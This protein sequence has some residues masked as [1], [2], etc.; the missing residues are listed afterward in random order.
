MNIID[1]TQ[2]SSRILQTRDHRRI[3]NAGQ[4]QPVSQ[5][6]GAFLH[7]TSFYNPDLDRYNYIIAHYVVLRSGVVL[8]VREPTTVL[9]SVSAGRAVDIEFEGDYPSYRRLRR[10]SW[11]ALLRYPTVP[12]LLAGRALLQELTNSLGISHVW[13]HLQASNLERDNCPGPQIWFNVAEWAVQNLGLSSTDLAR[14]IPPEWRDR[15]LDLIWPSP[16]PRPTDDVAFNRM[17]SQ[18]ARR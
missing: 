16:L 7:Q 1:R 17:I 11:G 6:R 9:N 10:N 3:I 18:L 13:A 4:V 2:H 5:I 15:H 12:Q 8:K 14:S